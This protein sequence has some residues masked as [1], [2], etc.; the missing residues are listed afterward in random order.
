MSLVEESELNIDG[1]VTY[2][3]IVGPQMSKFAKLMTESE[4]LQV[5]THYIFTRKVS[6]LSHKYFY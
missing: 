4:N 3:D 2:D 6:N 1:E 5:C